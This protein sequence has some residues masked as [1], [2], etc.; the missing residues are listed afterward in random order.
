MSRSRTEVRPR[1][2]QT[3]AYRHY[4]EGKKSHYEKIAKKT[5]LLKFKNIVVCV[6]TKKTLK[7]SRGFILLHKSRY[8]LQV[9]G[10]NKTIDVCN[11]LP[12]YTSVSHQPY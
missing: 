11:S 9:K 1:Q 4:V 7:I 12:E 5:K 10:K 6:S 8:L 3:S 2:T